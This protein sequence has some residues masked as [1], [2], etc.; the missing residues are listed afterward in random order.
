MQKDKRPMSK[1]EVQRY[2]NGKVVFIRWKMRRNSNDQ[3]DI[4]YDEHSRDYIDTASV[5]DGESYVDPFF[6]TGT[7]AQLF[8]YRM[9]REGSATKAW[10][11]AYNAQKVPT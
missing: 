10:Q 4:A 8:G 6:C 1:K 11:E 9:A 5:W 7:H 2:V 3:R